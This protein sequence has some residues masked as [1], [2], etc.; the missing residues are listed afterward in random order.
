VVIHNSDLPDVTIT[1]L[2]NATFI[3][4]LLGALKEEPTSGSI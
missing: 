1:D 4:D 3:A 2:L